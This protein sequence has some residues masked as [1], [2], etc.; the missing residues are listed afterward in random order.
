M[1]LLNLLDRTLSLLDRL[2]LRRGD[3]EQQTEHLVTGQRGEQAAFFYLRR[4]GYLITARR[5][6]SSRVRGDLD[7]VGWEKDTLCF[8]EVKTRSTRAVAP[9]EASVD[10][11]KQKVLSRLAFQYLSQ[12]QMEKIPVRFDI[13]SVYFEAGTAT[14]FELFRGAFDWQ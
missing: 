10:S 4:L 1:F 13:V 7:L 5:W 8:I 2:A 6:R 9:A 14:Q 12:L 11:Q 3:A